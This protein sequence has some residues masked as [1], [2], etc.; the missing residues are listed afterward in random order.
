[1]GDGATVAHTG[2]V[3]PNPDP[4]AHAGVPTDGVAVRVV[5]VDDQAPFRAAARAVVDRTPGFELVGEAADGA[6][7]LDVVAA[8]PV[9]LVLMDIK[10]PVLDGIA[11]TDRIRS[12]HRGVV[13]FLL[14]SHERASLP[15]DLTHCGA[16]TF[17]PK[18]DLSPAVLAGLWAEHSPDR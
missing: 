2:G 15:D 6:A 5:V 9:D 10:M 3:E 12:G 1:M 16:A 13:V 7:A 11:A 18:E 8:T 14:S 4:I 17:L